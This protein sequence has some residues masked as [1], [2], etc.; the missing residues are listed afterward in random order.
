MPARLR[1]LAAA[2]L[3]VW[4][5]PSRA[6]SESPRL[7]PTAVERARLYR[8]LSAEAAADFEE[9]HFDRAAEK[10]GRLVKEETKDGRA[11]AG[12]G[13]ALFETGDVERGVPALEEAIRLGFVDR[14]EGEYEIARNLARAGRSEEALSRLDQALAEGYRFRPK[15][16]ADAAFES[17]RSHPEFKRLAGELAPSDRAAGWR[18]DLQFFELE[19]SRVH[20]VYRRTP[21]PENFRS[22]AAAL[23]KDIERLS[24][25]QLTVRFQRLAAMLEDGHSLVWPFGMRRGDLSA[26]PLRL[27]LFEDGL[28]VVA[29]TEHPELIGRRVLS[30]GGVAATDALDRM[31]EYV[32]RD[33]DMSFRWAAPLYLTLAEYLEAIGA[34]V[35]ESSVEIGWEDAA[36]KPMTTNVRSAPVDPAKLETKLRPGEVS[37]PAA[38]PDYLRRMDESW[39]IHT[40]PRRRATYVL[41]NAVQD[42]EKESLAAFAARLRREL[43]RSRARAVVVD[44][45][46]NNGGNAELLPPLWR[47]LAGWA[48]EPGHRLYVIAGRQT[49]SAAQ[50]FVSSLSRLAPVTFAGEPTGSRPTHY[51]N[52]APFRLPYSGLRGTLS[53]GFNQTAARDARAWIPPDLPAALTSTDYFAGHDPALDAVLAEIEGGR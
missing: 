8:R 15:I 53:S 28:F 25:S 10:N 49:Y 26:L 36:G 13:R 51:G 7:P 17:L 52:E 37:S 16:A 20:P 34:R 1:V 48:G 41:F 23:E 11:W 32:S 12:L 44:V 50:T 33:N 42:S 31:R 35:R 5:I 9:K 30:I 19:I 4:M 39:W 24:D 22:S 47:V 43:M 38:A 40:L 2:A 3:A 45:R 46:N 27:Y 18:S 14:A 6:P 21:L 29:S